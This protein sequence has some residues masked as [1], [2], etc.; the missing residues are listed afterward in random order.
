MNGTS[1]LRLALDGTALAANW[2]WL[3]A[4]SGR[5]SCGAAIKAV[6][7]GGVVKTADADVAVVYYAGHGIEVDGTNY[8]IP[9]DAKL[10]SDF[11]IEDDLGY[12]RKFK[13]NIDAARPADQQPTPMP[14]PE[15]W[16]QD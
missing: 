16:P 3:A 12:I 9:I 13:A 4:Q 2:R 8:M 15:P 14:P 1:P 11:D 10:A 6:A 5:A 7:A